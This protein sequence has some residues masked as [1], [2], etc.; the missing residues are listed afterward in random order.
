MTN[1]NQNDERTKSS[2]SKDVLRWI[3]GLICFVGLPIVLVFLVA[4]LLPKPDLTRTEN[5]AR[6]IM[7]ILA[8]LP[9]EWWPYVLVVGLVGSYLTWSWHRYDSLCKEFEKQEAAENKDGLTRHDWWIAR[10]LRKRAFIL[11]IQAN[12]I[13]F[14]VFVL[15][16]GGVY[17]V[18][19][20]IPEVVI[21]EQ[22]VAQRVRFAALF[23]QKL[24]SIV[25]GRY[26]LKTDES[27]DGEA[28][29]NVDIKT[30][31]S[32]VT[33]GSVLMTTDGGKTWKRSS[34]PLQDGEEIIE[35]AF[36]SAD[37]K[38]VL[39]AGDRG[40]VLM[41]TRDGGQTWKRPSVPLQGGEEITAT[42]FSADGKTG[43][44]AGDRGSVL[45]T[46]DGG[47]TW[48]RPRVSLERREEIAVAALSADGKTGLVAGYEGL[49]LLTTDGG[50]TWN[51]PS[52]PLQNRESI[53]VAAF[54]SANGKTGLVAGYRGSVLMTTDGGQTWNRPSVPLQNR[55]RIAVAALS[56]NGKTGLVAGYRGSVLMTRDGG[57]TWKRSSVS[58]QNRERIP[59]AAL[60]ADGKTGLVAGHRG[61]VLMTTDGGKTWKRSSVPV[62]DTE[63]IVRAAL[64]VDGSARAF[65]VFKPSV[66]MTKDGGQTW[67]RSSVR[68]QRGEE[69]T[70]A[71]FSA[72]GKTGLVAGHRGSVL[73]TTD[74]G[75]TWNR[76]SVPLQGGEEIIEAAFI[77]ADGKTVLV[78]GDRGSV[79]LTTDEGQTWNRSSVRLQ[80]GE[81]IAKAAFSADGKTVLVAGDRGSALLT[82][83]GG[84]TWNRTEGLDPSS[85]LVKVGA[86][87]FSQ[88]SMEQTP[89]SIERGLDFI[90]Q[91]K[92]RNYYGLKPHPELRRWQEWSITDI[93]S[94]M[95]ED[96]DLQSSQVF[97]DISRFDDTFSDFSPNGD[98]ASKRSVVGL[99]HLDE[100]TLMRIATM[101]ILFFLVQIL[102]RLYQYNLRLSA[103]WDSRAD[104]M[105]LTRSFAEKKAERF[106]DLVGAL[107]PDA[108]DFKSPP[109]S[110]MDWFRLRSKS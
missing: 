94:K 15:L 74:G 43:L 44:V 68:L 87:D 4:W 2:I 35:A 14:S 26:W 98:K 12:L 67:N 29:F 107:G 61:S 17:L 13:L 45:M 91:T 66:F 58:L 101:T 78:A 33:E 81:E 32:E 96:K 80:R 38:T 20:S 110:P 99:F 18:L 100:L 84:Q 48:K 69:I 70:E 56:A 36:I 92:D 27:Y 30:A 57:Q 22:I 50:Q 52:V 63:W 88:G 51:R 49:V 8:Q 10:K 11:R 105:F 41:T 3:V 25:D 34:V 21:K 54:I 7:D 77:S 90:A 42:A 65:I 60:S 79:L 6:E 82:T 85:P 72:D 71:T 102:V 76:P 103:F 31:V 86:L 95:T 89:D 37:G 64:G 83:D 62:K 93:L 40:L 75:Q 106:D 24:Q 97:K 47:Q 53:P 104:A 16:F 109:Q 59:V 5:S 108:H 28:E 1:E 46:R 73:L 9:T 39:V 23:G 19:F 55:E